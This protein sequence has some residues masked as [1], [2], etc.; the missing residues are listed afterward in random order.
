MFR[1]IA[2]SGIAVATFGFAA[3]IPA[4]VT[5]HRDVLPVLQKRCQQCHRPGEAAPMSLLTYEETR[6]WA[7]SIREAVLLKKMPPW[8]ADPAHG[9]FSNER[10][11]SETEITILSKWAESGAAEGNPADAPQPQEFASSLEIGEPDLV[12]DVGYDYPVPASGEIPYTYFVVPTGLTED[13]WIE[14]VEARPGTRSVVHHIVV[15]TRPPNS[16]RFKEIKPGEPYVPQKKAKK[17]RKK[18][19]GAGVFEALNADGEMLAT[20][21]PGGVPYRT[22]PGEARLLP[23]G[24]DLIFQM[25]YTTN[26]TPALERSVIGI[27]FADVPPQRRVVNSF[28]SNRFLVISPGDSNRRVDA[29][30]TVHEDVELLSLFPHMHLSGKAFEYRAIF[31]SGESK[32][33]LSVP[34]YDFNWQLTYYLDEP[35]MLPKGTEIVAT[36]GYD[37]S[38]N[39]LFNPDPAET[40]YWGPQTWDEMLAGFLNFAIPVDLDPARIPKP[41]R[42]GI[43]LTQVTP[44]CSMGGSGELPT[45]SDRVRGSILQR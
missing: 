4:P 16:E 17:K 42:W 33:L 5:F 10:R 18:D 35:I 45:E 36:A 44:R 7:A 19:T 38:P 3:N 27:K 20:F 15:S 30:V 6:P 1:R 28:I 26:G 39:N 22:R 29:R 31:P 2:L 13:K 9:S 41:V 8:F 34:K 12:L 24:S 32:T 37:N 43:H 40:V 23:A 11:L 14:S 21:V 25:H